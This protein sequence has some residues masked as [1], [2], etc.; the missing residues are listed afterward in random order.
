MSVPSFSHKLDTR[1]DS[2]LIYNIDTVQTLKVPRS[3]CNNVTMYN[4][5]IETSNSHWK[6]AYTS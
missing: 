1:V 2:S 6:T 3:G 5:G 4:I